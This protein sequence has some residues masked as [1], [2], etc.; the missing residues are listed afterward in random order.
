MR[1][2]AN[3]L[4]LCILGLMG[5]L[6]FRV[7]FIGSGTFIGDSDRLN[8]LLN[9]RIFEVRA[10]Q[11]HLPLAWNE[12]EFMGFD[13]YGL[14]WIFVGV[15]P[16]AHLEALFPTAQLFRVAGYVACGLFVLAAWAAYFMIKAL[17]GAAFPS[18]V[19]AALY[20]L[21]TAAIVRIS[22]VDSTFAVLILIP[23]GLLIIR[24]LRRGNLAR[25]FLGLTLIMTLLLGATFLQEASYAILLF[26]AYALYRGLN[27]RDWRAP[28]LAITALIASA[29]IAS[30]R[31]ITIFLD[32]RSV[33][34]TATFFTTHWSEL[35]RWLDDGIFGR[36]PAEAQVLHNGLNLHEG[37]QLYTSTLAA[38]LVVT[39][40]MYFAGRAAVLGISRRRFGAGALPAHQQEADG[41][42]HLLFVVF[43]LAV[44]LIE[45]IRYLFYLAFAKA[46]LTHS[47]LSIAAL[48]S[49]CALVSILLQ[50]AF[51][52]SARRVSTRCKVMLLSVSLITAAVLSWLVQVLA[53]RTLE[54]HPGLDR[55]LDWR[56]GYTIL[57]VELMRVVWSMVVFGL[58]CG[59]LLATRRNALARY[60][61]SCCLGL[62]MIVQAFMY[63]D[64]QLF[65]PQTWTFPIPFNDHAF[66]NVKPEIFLPPDDRA[67][68][69][70]RARLESNRYRT[71]LVADPSKFPAFV[72]PHLSQFW[73]L[74]VLGGYA[75]G[76][77]R[78]LASLPWPEGVLSLR[79]LSFPDV[80]HLPW[81]LLS[82]LNVKYALVVNRPVYFNLHYVGSHFSS[83]A[84]LV[85]SKVVTNPLPVSP[86]EFFAATVVPAK[87]ASSPERA[88]LEVRAPTGVNVTVRSSDALLL[89]WV[90]V[91]PG[92]AY[93]IERR[94]GAAGPYRLVGIT[95][96][97][98]TSHLTTGLKPGT[99]YSSRLR[100]CKSTGCSPYSA[101]V[102]R[103][104]AVPSLAAPEDLSAVAISHDKIRLSW[105]RSF[106]GAYYRIGLEAGA[107][108]PYIPL[109]ATPPNALTFVVRG[110]AG[111][112]TYH[113]R[114]QGC[115]SEGCSPD[116]QAAS[117]TTP[118]ALTVS[119]LKGALPP[120]PT[121]VSVVEGFPAVERFSTTGA[122]HARYD[123]DRIEIQLDPS[124]DPRFLVINERYNPGWTAFAGGQRLRVYPTNVVM[125]GVV[126]PPNT[127]E[128]RFVFSPFLLTPV[129]G[130]IFAG[131]L[132][133]TCGLWLVCRRVDAERERSDGGNAEEVC[134]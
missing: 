68:Q 44:V 48:L 73:D 96:T 43:A 5:I 80:E 19:G 78:R 99:L 119:E 101:E 26:G 10:I 4:V 57:P 91:T 106:P 21:S 20:P 133:L 130:L 7:H 22:Q 103:F 110:L 89:S 47:R 115:T 12:N 24:R 50:D 56:V 40:T 112:T 51:G 39:G 9:L 13:T 86:R 53:A 85:D 97:D 114:V 102:N 59:A 95:G 104:T 37:L 126:V 61:L 116:S 123:G 121:K 18:F 3:V 41:P 132:A 14:P 134:G 1:R 127:T 34:R 120:D 107:A 60:G 28:I 108:G 70:L 11:H 38:L 76:V 35:L 92:A 90:D 8:S 100:A 124:T 122:I 117:V 84:Y 65:G 131:G 58:L 64:F 98:A 74:R 52:V 109:G 30:P 55:P 49:E 128:V 87:I 67:V 62:V 72:D 29:T 25:C 125:R 113:F 16:L 45:P 27:L 54:L 46:D 77:P 118:S 63:A 81:P 79:A 66:L 88:E 94:E 2:I 6:L 75:P 31:L 15:D 111:L 69:A 36:Y 71:V 33:A 93:W 129:A 23:V 82:I 83:G 32:I 17:G 105:R 42:F